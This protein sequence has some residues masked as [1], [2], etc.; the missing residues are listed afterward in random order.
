MCPHMKWPLLLAGCIALLGAGIHGVVGDRIVRRIEPD[1][2][3]ASRFGGG[4]S[5]KFLIRV[6]WHFVTIAF[7][8]AG[9]GLGAAGLQPR[10]D[11]A[12]GLAY[13]AAALITCWALFGLAGSHARAGIRAWTKHPAPVILTLTSALAWWGA[14][15]L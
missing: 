1:S 11:A 12:T 14:A 4:S 5:T 7:V 3:P 8:I 6:S 13:E 2:L 15:T 10:W 9:I